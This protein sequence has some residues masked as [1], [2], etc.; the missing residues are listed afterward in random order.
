[1]HLVPSPWQLQKDPQSRGNIHHDFLALSS[2]PLIF[3][4]IGTVCLKHSPSSFNTPHQT[5]KCILSVSYRSSPPFSTDSIDVPAA[6]GR[7]VL[8]FLD[9]QQPLDMKARWKVSLHSCSIWN[10]QIQGYRKCFLLVLYHTWE[11][12]QC[13]KESQRHFGYHD[14]LVK[15]SGHQGSIRYGVLV[16]WFKNIAVQSDTL[17]RPLAFC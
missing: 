8:N 14:V 15:Y 2:C 7:A 17:L 1:M 9:L 13:P 3:I 4:N 6:C 16:S 10:P 5:H 11:A 12:M